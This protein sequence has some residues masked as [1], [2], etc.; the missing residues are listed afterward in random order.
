MKT[1]V[2][3]GGGQ[4]A[5]ALL[6]TTVEDHEVCVHGVETLDITSPR[7]VDDV[8]RCM[9]P[10]MI[11][12]TAAFTAV[13]DAESDECFAAKVNDRGPGILAE[14]AKK[15]G[16]RLL[17]IST[18]F[19]FDG[20][21]SRP[22]LTTDPTNPIS[23]Y[24]RTKRD[25]ERA[26]MDSGLEEWTIVRTAWLY[27]GTSPN[28]FSTMI[29]LMNER[30]EIGVV[31]DQ[32]GTPTLA[33]SLA[34]AVWCLVEKGTT[35]MHHWTDSGSTTWHGFATAI[36]EIARETGLLE[37]R[38]IIKPIATEEY[39]TPARRPG[40]SVLDMTKTWNALEGTRAMPPVDW[41]ENLKKMI[42][43]K[44]RV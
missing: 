33:D 32:T 15:Y 6:R 29:R 9:R 7:Q 27:D 30:D 36:E 20:S 21:S 42:K 25:G 19:V 23:V 39:P 26:V 1:L 8:V 37:S 41:R 14:A 12:N 4:L 31:S 17:H 18:D 5:K 22:W 2:T 40:F 3:G 11:I 38:T 35:G 44:V 16:S 28:F 34:N 43:E 10:E 24:G 13:D